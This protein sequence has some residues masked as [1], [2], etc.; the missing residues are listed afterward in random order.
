MQIHNVR[1]SNLGLEAHLASMSQIITKVDPCAVVIDPISNFI[2]AA[3]QSGVKSMLIRLVDF[4]KM[5]QITALFTHLTSFST[6]PD[7]TYEKISSIMDTWILLR[8]L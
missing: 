7:R 3:D 4:L 1:P 6:S 2:T 8:D 5:R